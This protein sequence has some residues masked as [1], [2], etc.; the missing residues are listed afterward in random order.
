MSLSKVIY[1]PTVYKATQHQAADWVLQVYKL[2]YAPLMDY[3]SPPTPTCRQKFHFPLQVVASSN[4]TQEP[5]PKLLRRW[6]LRRSTPSSLS[7]SLSCPC[8]YRAKGL[9]YWNLGGL[10]TLSFISGYFVDCV[11]YPYIRIFRTFMSLCQGILKFNVT[12][13]GYFGHF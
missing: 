1:Y 4:F 7:L 13:L 3:L 8:S 5:C 12:I 2:S 6:T 10:K 9:A 11:S